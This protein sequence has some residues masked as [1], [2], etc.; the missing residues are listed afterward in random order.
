MLLRLLVRAIT[1][2]GRVRRRARFAAG[3]GVAS[4]AGAQA[5]EHDTSP[6]DVSRFAHRWTLRAV[7]AHAG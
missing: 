6:A 5:P 4:A 3:A 7:D 2:E 1:P